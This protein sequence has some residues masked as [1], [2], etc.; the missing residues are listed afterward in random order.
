MGFYAATNKNEIMAFAGKLMA[1][2]I[3]M[4]REISQTQNDS[5]IFFYREN[6]D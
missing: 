4:L 3:I 5:S 6:L 2:E 1:L